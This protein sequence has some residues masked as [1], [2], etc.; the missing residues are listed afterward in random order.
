M[1]GASAVG[2]EIYDDRNEI[3]IGYQ[4]ISS[5]V[6]EVSDYR[7]PNIFVSFAAK[8]Y[9]LINGTNPA[10]YHP[11][12]SGV[13]VGTFGAQA[14]TTDYDG[15]PRPQGAAHD[16]G[17]Y[18]LPLTSVHTRSGSVTRKSTASTAR[19]GGFG[20]SALAVDRHITT[21]TRAG[22]FVRSANV[23]TRHAIA[24]SKQL[25]GGQPTIHSRSALITTRKTPTTTRAGTFVRS[26]SET[27]RRTLTGSRGGAHVRSSSITTKRT[28]TGT[29]Q[30]GAVA[31]SEQKLAGIVESGKID[32][33]VM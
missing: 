12:D 11:V 20:R 21:G 33:K 15:L 7:W 25:T 18:E 13:Q 31:A 10:P 28:P 14:P 24:S 1:I 29:P 5:I 23:S 3:P 32:G 19:D 2:E 26:K 4:S 9:H 30:K 6:L 22:S 16:M 17:A 27:A 8:N